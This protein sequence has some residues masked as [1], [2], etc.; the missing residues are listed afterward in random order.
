MTLTPAQVKTAVTIG[1]YGGC[2]PA[3]DGGAIITGHFNLAGCVTVIIQKPSPQEGGVIPMA[4]GEIANMYQPVEDQPGWWT[5]IDDP[6]G[7]P[8]QIIKIIVKIG[9]KEFEKY[10]LVTERTRERTVTVANFINATEER[11][12]V[13]VKNIR[14]LPNRAKVTIQNFV[15]KWWS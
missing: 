11:I 6:T 7:P 14:R 2:L 10:A 13:A 5:R 9:E 15:K 4:P 12:K 1:K 8:R 3:C